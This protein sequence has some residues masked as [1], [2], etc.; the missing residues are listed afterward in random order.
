MNLFDYTT[1][2]APSLERAL[3]T[4][5]KT[6]L[7]RHNVVERQKIYGFNEIPEKIPAWWHF[8]LQQLKS[9]FLLV[10]MAAALLSFFL[11]G[12]STGLMIG[13][14]VVVNTVVGF[15]QEFMADRS[16]RLLKN[17]IPRTIIVVRDGKDVEIPS[18]ALVPGDIV[19]IEAGTI[20]PADIRF[21]EADELMVDESALTGESIAVRKQCS[22]L[23][24]PAE[25]V[26]QATNI[27][28]SGSMV[29]VGRGTGIVLETGPRA[30]QG[31]LGVLASTIVSESVFAQE[32]SHFTSL[33]LKVIVVFCAFFI[34]LH[35]TWGG[36]QAD[37][38]QMV[39]FAISLAITITPE[40]LPIIILFT[41]S[42]SARRLAQDHVIVKRL[43]AVNDL[44]SI[45][46][47]CVDKTGTLTENKMMV[48]DFKTDNEER[49]FL[50]AALA[51]EHPHVEGRVAHSLD[52]AIWQRV[53]DVMHEAIGAHTTVR[54]IP[55]D[56]AKRSNAVVVDMDG[57]RL[58][59]LRGAYEVVA[60]E[61]GI[62][63]QDP[64]AAWAAE[65]GNL[66]RRVLAV[67]VNNELMGLI[68]FSDP[69]KPTVTESIKT[70]QRLH[71][72]VK[73]ITGDAPEV[74]G[75]IA[76]Q[77]GIITSM[78]EV[79]LG[80]T[81]ARMS[82]EELAHTVE[83]C[84]VFAR[85]AP[86]QKFLIVQTL[87]KKHAVGF[88][89]DGI[90]DVLALKAA[91]V[92]IVVQGCAD[93]AREA[94]DIVLLQ[95][96][97]G[98]IVE[99]IRQGRAAVINTKKYV[100]ATLTSGIGSFFT[101][102]ISSLFIDFLPL[103]P[104]QI[105]L[106]NFLSDFPMLA[107]SGDTVDE[108]ELK[109][110]ARF[111]MSWLL[112]LVMVLGSLTALFLLLFFYMFVDEPQAMLQTNWFMATMLT[113]LV[114]IF[115]IRTKKPFWRA[116]RPAGMLFLLSSMVA[117]AVVLIPATAFGQQFFGFVAPSLEWLQ[118]VFAVTLGY[119]I[120]IEITKLLLY[121]FRIKITQT[122]G[123]IFFR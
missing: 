30:L 3:S 26:V 116:H 15:Y 12:Y 33:L 35:M 104:V 72:H 93:S 8:L 36:Y 88:M 7:Q 38:F 6:G 85:V 66:G 56:P 44:G 68:S 55:F 24:A 91:H 4:S 27:G 122:V 10:L 69:L 90:N 37:L 28:F 113:E 21:I 117:C 80:A 18:R 53:T 13:L 9:P 23:D 32:I 25:S 54:V 108:D 20:I 39:M 52:D 14:I 29:I 58:H 81:V 22:A 119:F 110:S 1:Y 31:S 83:K 73:L 70:A 34:V 101:L 96:S 105:L 11:D 65:Q 2:D 77:S 95:K 46:I 41:L 75:A 49:L 64:R 107:L 84:H 43:S 111:D 94:A 118:I 76:L 92:G 16:V 82:P 78:Q 120:A 106:L 114:L 89:G 121:R 45:Q 19:V 59:I 51:C 61:C 99:G 67:A 102:A 5:I 103:Q 115:S 42:R 109:T 74:A 87:Q 47:L 100:T 97:L 79:V 62:A 60:Q 112:I 50:Y 17:M 71:V 40:A 123:S 98:S 57:K 63:A 86:D 48:A